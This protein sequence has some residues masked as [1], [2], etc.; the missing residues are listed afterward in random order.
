MNKKIIVGIVVIAI[1]VVAAILIMSK[2]PVPV[3]TNMKEPQPSNTT[4]EPIPT[5]PQAT[6]S[7]SGNVPAP[8]PSPAGPAGPMQ[9][10]A[11]INIQNFQFDSPLFT[12]KKGTTVVWNNSDGMAHT[13]TSDGG[14]ELAS[15]S[16]G[17]GGSY[18]HTFNS[19]GTFT[20][21]C[22]IHPSMKGTVV[23]TN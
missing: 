23:V 12:V 20:Y 10:V 4:Q 16:I 1:V 8:S 2:G 15:P 11:L 5:N 19:V 7:P 22:S 21:H 3:N 17:H 18:Q 13:V 14:S 6:T 9:Q